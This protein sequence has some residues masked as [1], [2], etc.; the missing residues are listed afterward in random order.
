MKNLLIILFFLPLMSLA[1]GRPPT[2]SQTLEGEIEVPVLQ[3][4]VVE[5]I[6]AAP[7]KFETPDD[8]N[9][10]KLVSG[11]YKITVISNVPWVV[12]VSAA[13]PFFANGS[14]ANQKMPVSSIALRGST[15]AFIP[16]STVPVTLLKNTND[17]IM[18]VFYIDARVHAQF[19]F[20]SGKF[21][22]DLLFSISPD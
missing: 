20:G 22:T 16:L 10:N 18:N 5:L 8:V 2:G 15:G 21:K 13:N 7:I 6:N 9:S 17:K 3:S 1:Q 4:I 19:E 12:N 14:S 11:L